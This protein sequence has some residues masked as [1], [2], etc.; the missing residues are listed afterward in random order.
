M[1]KVLLA[2]LIIIFSFYSIKLVKANPSRLH[3][4][5]R[6][7]KDDNDNIVRLKGATVYWRF[8]YASAGSNYDPLSYSD[9]I[10][11]TSI[12]LF[13]STGANF[14]RLALNGY[15]YHVLEAQ[16]YKD[17]VDTV[18]GWC[19]ARNIMVVLDNHEWFNPDAGEE[20]WNKSKGGW[21]GQVDEI[22]EPPPGSQWVDYTPEEAWV[23]WRNNVLEVC[24]AIHA[25]NPSYLCFV[26]PLGSSAQIDDMNNFKIDPLPEPNIV[27]STHK[28]Y[29]WNYYT[30]GP[31]YAQSYAE[32]NF[33][34]AREEME[35]YYNETFMYMTDVNL[36]VMNMETGVY[37]DPSKNPNWDVWVNDSLSLYEEYGVSVSWY[38][39]DPDR[40]SSSLISLLKADRISLTEV[41]EIWAEHMVSD[42]ITTS[43][44]T[45]TTIQTTSTTTLTTT[46]IP[47]GQITVS[48]QFLN[49][50][51]PIEANI[52]IYNQGTE[53]I[54][55]SA[56]TSGGDYSLSVWPDVYDLQ[57]SILEFFISNFFIKLMSLDIVSD[58][59]NVVNYV[60]ESSKNINFTVNI[61][62]DQEIQVYSEQVPKAVKA[63]GVQLTGT[64]SLPI[65]T[66]EWFYAS[67]QK[68]LYINVS[69]V[70]ATTT[71][72]PT[73]TTSTTTIPGSTTTTTIPTGYIF[74]DGFEG[75]DEDWNTYT[76]T[77]ETIDLNCNSYPH[78]G[79]EHL[80]ATCDA[81]G[82]VDFAYAYT[83]FTGQDEVYVRG[84][85]NFTKVPSDFPSGS[86]Y[87]D[88]V[89]MVLLAETGDQLMLQFGLIVE[90]TTEYWKINYRD[91]ASWPNS[92]VETNYE[93]S[94]SYSFEVYWKKH[95]TEGQV[96][97]WVD[98]VLI[99]NI[100]GI[101][102]DD[103]GNVDTVRVGVTYG[104][105][106]LTES[107]S[108][109]AD[110]IVVDDA[111]IGP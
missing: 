87:R 65:S 60:T 14:I 25:V 64:S 1:K 104:G 100:T 20:Y 57:Y 36:P 74:S 73:T 15:L 63:N 93:N 101:D 84:H 99:H 102:S 98:G 109:F 30:G 107:Y 53:T 22:N 18:I 34:T 50:T 85:F 108:V 71:T 5:G 59:P 45:T 89:S 66:N 88:L 96:M 49:S 81:D 8:M 105:S 38:P 17:A 9:E 12:D 7:I 6:W 69:S 31:A 48:G 42:D 61:S 10:N 83:T 82:A 19:K 13:D 91:G 27:Y 28:Y 78:Q 62:T 106:G 77:G 103:Y 94:T 37:R 110:D 75:S 32:G 21:Y 40:E 16:E 70:T 4:E 92:L 90:G 67:S 24:Q 54:N 72:T 95:D 80:N 41:G 39:F 44:S 46:T 11:E 33:E 23:I 2:V 51:G 43:T 52:S 29:A 68:K 3:T 35:T 76:S 97:S 26:E 79:N 55:T 47:L 111:Y 56:I 58:L 86:G